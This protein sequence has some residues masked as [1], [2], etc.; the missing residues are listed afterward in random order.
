MLD[1]LRAMERRMFELSLDRIKRER[2]HLDELELR[3][4][5]AARRL[6]IGEPVNALYVNHEG[7]EC[8]GCEG[9]EAEEEAL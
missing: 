5:D 2:V 8:G 9:C 7:P 3:L 6:G 4:H 1:H